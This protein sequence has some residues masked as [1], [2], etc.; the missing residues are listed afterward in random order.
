MFQPVM[1]A[2]AFDEFVLVDDYIPQEE[3]RKQH[4]M[5]KAGE[6]VKVLQQK[7]SGMYIHVVWHSLMYYFTHSMTCASFLITHFSFRVVAG[8]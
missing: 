6:V 7:E 4:L 5:A 1:P 3:D 2:G 8:M